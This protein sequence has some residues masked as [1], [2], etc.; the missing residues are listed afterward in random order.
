MV[1]LNDTFENVA[2]PYRYGTGIYNTRFVDLAFTLTYLSHV[3]MYV[4]QAL[5]DSHILR[6]HKYLLWSIAPQRGDTGHFLRDT[7]FLPPHRFLL[8]V[9]TCRSRAF[10]HLENFVDLCKLS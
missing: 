7:C 2:E 4:S 3:S 5:S 9:H 1:F 10:R 6:M 8:L